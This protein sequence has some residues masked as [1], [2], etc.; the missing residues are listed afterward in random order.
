MQSVATHISAG[1][2]SR[3]FGDIIVLTLSIK[4]ILLPEVYSISIFFKYIDT[5]IV[6]P[7]SFNKNH[8]F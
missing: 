7:S 6:L 1:N 2:V 4:A 5:H 3:E 8:V